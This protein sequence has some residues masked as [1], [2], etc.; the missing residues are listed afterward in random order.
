M[1]SSLAVTLSARGCGGEPG[2]NDLSSASQ[3]QAE[4]F[5]AQRT[6][7][8]QER[9]FLPQTRGSEVPDDA[10]GRENEVTSHHE[11]GILI[12]CTWR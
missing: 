10:G 3:L 5:V 1:H 11:R 7:R 4:S 2:A 12:C 9:P 6:H 8:V